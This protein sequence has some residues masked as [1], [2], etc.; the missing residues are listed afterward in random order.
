MPESSMDCVHEWRRPRGFSHQQSCGYFVEATVFF[1]VLLGCCH[2]VDLVCVDS[3]T[4]QEMLR[5]RVI[6]SV[7]GYCFKFFCSKSPAL[8]T[9]EGWE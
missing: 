3:L 1:P 8:E 9:G 4:F 2:T 6:G 5:L 7:F